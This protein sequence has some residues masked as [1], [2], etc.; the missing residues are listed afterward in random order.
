MGDRHSFPRWIF[1]ATAADGR[2]L[3]SGTRLVLSALWSYATWWDDRDGSS[4]VFP[5]ATT[6]ARITGYN[7]RTIWKQLRQLQDAGLISRER[8]PVPGGRVFEGWRLKRLDEPLPEGTVD[9]GQGGTL[10]AEPPGLRGHSDLP[11]RTPDPAPRCTETLPHRPAED[12]QEEPQEEPPQAPKKPSAQS[13][14][15]DKVLAYMRNAV[16]TLTGK[17]GGP[18]NVQTNRKMVIDA[19]KR[20]GAS[21]EDWQRVIDGQ[22][23]DV[24]NRPSAWRYLCL[25][26]ITRPKNWARLADA[27]VGDHR[28]RASAFSPSLFDDHHPQPE[29]ELVPEPEAPDFTLNPDDPEDFPL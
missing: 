16:L 9:P 20:E 28:E 14:L 12:P 22:L 5:S 29:P 6:L 8:R 21:L 7:D 13:V 25:S 26:T 23:A 4:W 10:N 3:P 19:T 27:P 17:P 15:V 1:A 2:L 11:H 18:R 24:R